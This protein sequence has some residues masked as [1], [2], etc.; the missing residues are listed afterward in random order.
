M[1][2][3]AV[4]ISKFNLEDHRLIWRT[5]GAPFVANSSN[6]IRVPLNLSTVN[7]SL[8]NAKRLL[9]SVRETTF[10]IHGTFTQLCLIFTA[11]HTVCKDSRLVFRCLRQL[12][13]IDNQM[14]RYPFWFKIPTRREPLT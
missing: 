4:L 13:L 12:F 8:V 2:L 5:T 10:S 6:N 3:K 14:P 9:L 1:R 7:Q 11:R